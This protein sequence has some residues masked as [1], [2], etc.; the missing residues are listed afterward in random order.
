[1]NTMSLRQSLRWSM[2]DFYKSKI[3]SNAGYST[4]TKSI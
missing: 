3:P 4:G 2:K 1:M